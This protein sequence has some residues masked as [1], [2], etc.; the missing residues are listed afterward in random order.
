MSKKVTSYTPEE[1]ERDYAHED[2]KPVP[3]S[4]A[5]AALRASVGVYGGFEVEPAPVPSYA[6]T[7]NL[8]RDGC[9]MI[10][11]AYIFLSILDD[12]CPP[13][14][15][16]FILCL[17][18]ISRG[19]SAEHIIITDD[20]IAAHMGHNRNRV[21][22]KR[23]AL[24]EWEQ[25]NDY[26]IIKVREREFNTDKGRYD[27][28]MYQVLITDF[29]AEF[30]RLARENFQWKPSFQIEKGVEEGLKQTAKRVSE[31]IPNAEIVRR[32][33]AKKLKVPPSHS[34]V[35]KLRE[36]KAL[37]LITECMAITEEWGGSGE[38]WLDE[39]LVVAA[40]SQPKERERNLARRLKREI[41]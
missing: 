18:G 15:R 4:S 3:T 25:K 22:E 11:A 26:S 33:K 8:E 2:S 27:P 1:F 40:Q 34:A 29:V 10:K 17:M 41:S 13:D 9:D 31:R 28:T 21:A 23:R 39:F 14:A 6:R 12:P 5:V 32:S 16:D 7:D 37:K 30:L 24:I 35:L 38:V 19:N 36:G 20:Q